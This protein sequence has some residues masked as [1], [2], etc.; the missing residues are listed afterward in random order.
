MHPSAA[1]SVAACSVVP[2]RSAKPTTANVTPRFIS[3][4]R[5][6]ELIYLQSGQQPDVA[7]LVA[8][9][10]A[11]AVVATATATSAMTFG[12][13]VSSFILRSLW[14]ASGESD[15]VVRIRVAVALKVKWPALLTFEPT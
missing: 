12:L 8:A 9:L 7:S 11:L 3:P 15:D 2:I 10:A 14:S 13:N 5:L 4:P 6:I 1:C